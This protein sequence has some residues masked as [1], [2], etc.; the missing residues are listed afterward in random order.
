MTTVEWDEAKARSNFEK[1]GVSFERALDLDWSRSLAIQD[2]RRDYGEDR[3]IA[4]AP[5]GDRL[6]ALVYALR[7]G[8]RRVISLRKANARE[9]RKYEEARKARRS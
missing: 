5:I 3:F 9:V 2:E 4:Y 8:T 7:S 6:Y 1:H